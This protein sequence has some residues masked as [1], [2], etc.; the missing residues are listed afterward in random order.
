ML[1]PCSNQCLSNCRSPLANRQSFPIS[2]LRLCNESVELVLSLKNRVKWQAR[3][4]TY[5]R[6]TDQTHQNNCSPTSHDADNSTRN[7]PSI[8]SPLAAG[9]IPAILLE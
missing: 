9:L 8:N 4:G 5:R 2:C 7:S 1:V 3:G 6:R